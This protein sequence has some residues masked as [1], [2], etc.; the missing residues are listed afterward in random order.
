[1]LGSIARDPERLAP[2]LPSPRA[3]A[4]AVAEAREPNG[5]GADGEQ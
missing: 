4:P 1:V 2:A 5:S 3:D